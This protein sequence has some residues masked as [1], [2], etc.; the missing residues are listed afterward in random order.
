MSQ[1]YIKTGDLTKVVEWDRN[2]RRDALAS[3]EELQESLRR[4]GQAHCHPSTASHAA[5]V[6]WP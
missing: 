2:P 1:K 3:T 6:M 5:A 4:V